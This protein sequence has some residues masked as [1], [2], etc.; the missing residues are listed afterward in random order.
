[1]QSKEKR[2]MDA[3]SSNKEFIKNSI[4]FH[5]DKK[6]LQHISYLLC[7]RKE[8][9]CKYC[10]YLSAIHLGL[11]DLRTTLFRHIGSLQSKCVHTRL[12]TCPDPWLFAGLWD[13]SCSEVLEC[14]SQG[15][16]IAKLTACSLARSWPTQPRALP[17]ISWSCSMD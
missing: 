5:P 8:N 17:N 2:Q 1:M 9:I 14:E 4:H 13:H 12:G 6:C 15:H 11:T 7:D 16:P 3:V 10:I